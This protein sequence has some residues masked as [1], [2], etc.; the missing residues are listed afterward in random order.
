MRDGGKPCAFRVSAGGGALWLPAWIGAS[1]KGRSQQLIILLMVDGLR[2]VVDAIAAA[3][4]LALLRFYR[5]TSV[6]AEFYS[7]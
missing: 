7:P 6:A 2:V 5:A 4:Q 3:S 1:V